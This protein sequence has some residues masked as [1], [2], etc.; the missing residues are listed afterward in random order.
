MARAIGTTR[1]FSCVVNLCGLSYRGV[2]RLPSYLQKRF[3]RW[4]AVLEIP[5]GLRS[6]L[7]GKPRFVKSL[8]TDSRSI[9]LRRA[10][11]IVARWKQEIEQARGQPN[12]DDATFWR[13]ALRGAKTEKERETI[14]EQIDMAAWE[15]GAVNVDEI[16]Q[17]ASRDPAAREF[18]GKATGAVVP[19]TEY[20]D[21][22]LATFSGTPKTKDMHKAAITRFAKDF[23]M[24]S[25]VKRPEVR[26]WV[27]SMMNGEGKSP[28]TMAR[29]LSG[30]RTYWRY[31][32]TIKIA[33]EDDEPFSKLGIAHE[34]KR[35][36]PQSLRRP[37]DPADVVALMAAAAKDKELVD[38]IDV[39]RWTGAR[40]EEICALKIEH[41]KGEY[42]TVQDAKTA[43]GWRDVPIHTK[44]APTIERLIGDRK[45]GWLFNDLTK[46]KYG[47]RSNAIGKRFGKLKANSFG[48]QF[49]FH[50]FRKTFVTLLEN[51]GVPESV[52]ASLVGHDVPTLTFG[53]Y[54]G[55]VSLA[56]KREALE[57]L[58]Y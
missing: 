37:F 18:F 30:I 53:L 50:S 49:V 40:I 20:L 12:T 29:V 10:A 15:I 26:R 2:P 7:E 38:L 21:E 46:N 8:E 4:Y 47:D 44:L 24:V 9:A 11:P 3:R 1:R 42:F 22:W 51:A 48:P 5:K 19:L 6:H 56:V 36:A 35:T 58:V 16:G 31:L 17:D 27:T 41:V 43:A 45:D 33:G 23:P 28:K 14:L 57:K 39:A 54:S 52:V 34:V 13:D 32:Q 55:G 25:D